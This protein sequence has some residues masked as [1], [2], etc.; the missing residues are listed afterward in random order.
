MPTSI[1]RHHAD[2]LSLVEVSGP[3]LTLPVLARALPQG[4]DPV[5]PA[6]V[7]EL[8]RAYEEYQ[9]DSS[10]HGRWIRWVLSELLS[11]DGEM[12]REGPAVPAA[13]THLAAEHGETLRPDLAVCEQRDDG[14]LVPRL[15][16]SI[17][18]LATAL[19]EKLSDRSYPASPLERAA[20]LLRAAGVRLGLVTNGERWTLVHA[21][22]GRPTTYAT[23]EAA[24]WLEERPTLDAFATL[25]GAHRFFSVAESDT[26]EA[27][28]AESADAEQEVTDQLGRQVRQAVELLV[29]ALSRANREQGGEL[30]RD[31][32]PERLYLASVTVMMRLVFLLCAEER[33]LFLLSDR[34]TTRPTPSRR[35]AGNSRRRQTASARSRSSAARRRGTACS[36]PSGWC[37]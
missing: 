17:W 26:L 2:W 34:S 8:R 22:A 18:P 31:V 37:T 4:L 33:G 25:L 36:P 20:E 1:D 9:A 11:F 16:V 30:L 19:D 32:S 10:L 28:F 23:W 7:G 21:A 27:L 6:T 3:F 5:D 29:D 35:C 14:A 15:L 13:L 12:L 24:V